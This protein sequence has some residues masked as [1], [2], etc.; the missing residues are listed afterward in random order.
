VD[1][2]K[3]IRV[4]ISIIILSLL[5]LLPGLVSEARAETRITITVAAGGVACGIYFFLQYAFRTSL[6]I[7]QN[8]IETTAIFN[9]GPEDWQIRFPTL[10]LIGSEHRN[11]SFSVHA[12]EAVQLNVLKWRF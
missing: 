3:C 8:Q 11:A 1:K 12:P 9:L 7:Q 5:F 2:K 6:S 10:N 4:L